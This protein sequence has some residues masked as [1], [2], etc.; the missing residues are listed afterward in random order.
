MATTADFLKTD[1]RMFGFSP[2]TRPTGEGQGYGGVTSQLP[3][4]PDDLLTSRGL[5][6]TN[7][8]MAGYS[9]DG[10]LGHSRLAPNSLKELNGPYGSSSL[11]PQLHNSNMSPNGYLGNN[12]LNLMSQHQQR[13]QQHHQGHHLHHPGQTQQPHLHHHLQHYPSSAISPV[14]SNGSNGNA[15]NNNNNTSKLRLSGE[16]LSC[17]GNNNNNPYNSPTPTGSPRTPTGMCGN[18]NASSNSNNNTNNNNNNNNC[19]RQSLVSMGNSVNPPSNSNSSNNNNNNDNSTHILDSGISQTISPPRMKKEDIFGTDLQQHDTTTFTSATKPDPNL[20]T[21][22]STNDKNTTSG[23]FNSNRKG[24][25][26][27]AKITTNSSSSGNNNHH[28]EEP[29]ENEADEDDA[30]LDSRG[31]EGGGGGS[32]EDGEDGEPKRKKR[33]NRT[34]FTSFQLEE[35]ERVFQK[36]HYPDVYA[37]EQL[38]L[39][40]SLTEARVQKEKGKGKEGMVR[41]GLKPEVRQVPCEPGQ[42]SQGSGGGAPVSP[43]GSFMVVV[44]NDGQSPRQIFVGV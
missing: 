1:G 21:N 25:S 19:D 20:S 12:H 8:R 31:G 18:P 22:T 13:H 33:R 17:S 23:I 3:S 16:R 34:T 27:K 36:T 35:M 28:D 9:I 30:C 41:S 11:S 29:D 32:L 15:S 4:H 38:A 10:I 44:G 26:T 37:R 14:S 6:D 43:V 39:R 7:Q 2:L 42:A 5:L 24:Y 40:C